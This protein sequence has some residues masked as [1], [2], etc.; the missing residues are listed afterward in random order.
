MTL[1]SSHEALLDR[2]FLELIAK[3]KAHLQNQSEQ[4]PTLGLSFT[5]AAAAIEAGGLIESVFYQEER[6]AFP[7]ELEELRKTN[8]GSKEN[9]VDLLVQFS[10]QANISGDEAYRALKEY[11]GNIPKSGTSN[12][13]SYAEKLQRIRLIK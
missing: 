7:I 2:L 5:S 6:Y 4:M 3:I 11:I 12:E 8:Q 13:R 10:Q 9:V 1:S